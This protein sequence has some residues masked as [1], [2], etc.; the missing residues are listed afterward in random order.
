VKLRTPTTNSKFQTPSSKDTK[1]QAQKTTGAPFATASDFEVWCLRFG[2]SLEL[3]VWCLVFR[4]VIAQKVRC[5][6]P[7]LPCSAPV[8][9]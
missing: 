5:A 7:F 6:L 9:F 1:H 4:L 8:L 3:G 2:T